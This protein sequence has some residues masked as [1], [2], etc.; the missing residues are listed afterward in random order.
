[1]FQI[2]TV[3]QGEFHFAVFLKRFITF[4]PIKSAR[5]L[6][7]NEEAE[8]VSRP[9]IIHEQYLKLTG[10]LKGKENTVLLLVQIIYCTW[11]CIGKACGLIC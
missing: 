2:S 6:G 11:L 7:R 4:N 1:M 9:T 10:Y 8:A 3:L 5:L